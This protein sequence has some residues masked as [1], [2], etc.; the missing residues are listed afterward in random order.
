M[1]T[2]VHTSHG[3]GAQVHPAHAKI[4]M[5]INTLQASCHI[6]KWPIYVVRTQCPRC[7]TI[8]TGL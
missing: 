7:Q 1:T 2:T 3:R 5:S 8:I 4:K 6:H